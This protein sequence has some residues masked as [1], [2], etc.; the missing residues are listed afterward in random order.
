MNGISVLIKKMPESF[1]QVQTGRALC[2]LGIHEGPGLDEVLHRVQVVVLRGLHQRGPLVLGAGVDVGARLDQH[3]AD[4]H[5]ASLCRGVQGRALVLMLHLEVGVDPVNQ[6][7]QHLLQLPLPRREVQLLRVVAELL[8]FLGIQGDEC[9]LQGL[10]P[11]A[12]RL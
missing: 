7:E 9:A 2:V 3:V 6:H 4:V 8:G 11:R 5:V 12:K 1:G 10:L